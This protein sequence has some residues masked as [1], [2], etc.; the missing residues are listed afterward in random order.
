MRRVTENHQRRRDTHCS[1][2]NRPMRGVPVGVHL[3]LP[4]GGVICS[5]CVRRA[6]NKK[7]F[8]LVA[9]GERPEHRAAAM[10]EWRAA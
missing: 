9:D 10:G 4:K 1:V 3:S 6:R 2:C 7:R 8:D 5:G